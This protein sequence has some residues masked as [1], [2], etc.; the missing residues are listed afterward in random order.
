M[1]AEREEATR[2]GSIL[3]STSRVT[4]L[5]ESFVW[6]VD[7]TRWPVRDAWIA[8]SAVSESRISPTMM[9]S[10]NFV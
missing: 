7:S 6:R 3:I 8:I 4:A 10:Y 9:M 2:K 5:A 1:T